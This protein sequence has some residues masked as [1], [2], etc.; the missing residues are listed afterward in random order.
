MSQEA[1]GNLFSER[2]IK[3][4]RGLVFLNTM[5]NLIFIRAQYNNI[6]LVMAGLLG[7]LENR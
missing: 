2:V 1:F 7:S 4:S 5:K 6:K 3:T